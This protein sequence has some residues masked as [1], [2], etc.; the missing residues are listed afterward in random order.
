M[1]VHFFGILTSCPPI[2]ILIIP[3]EGYFN[4]VL[5]GANDPSPAPQ[6]CKIVF[7]RS[8]HTIIQI[9]SET[10]HPAHNYF[11]FLPSNVRLWVFKCCKRL[12]GSFC[13]TAV[14]VYYKV[15]FKS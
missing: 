15:N 13:P 14:K 2:P 10:E 9:I 3:F 1:I 7:K 12:T 6:R 11:K 8:Q 4:T 5:A